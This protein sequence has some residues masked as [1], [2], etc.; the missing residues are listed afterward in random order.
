MKRGYTAVPKAVLVMTVLLL[1]GCMV[2]E[3]SNYPKPVDE[4]KM[5]TTHINLGLRYV[6]RGNREMARHHLDKA[7]AIDSRSS[8]ALTGYALVYEQEGEHEL[9]EDNF[10]RAMSADPSDTR[11][12]FYYAVY[13]NTRD[14]FVEAR[15]HFIQVTE[16]VGY[17]HRALAFASLGQVEAEMGN[18]DAARQALER[19]L[20]INPK[21]P[22]VYMELAELEYQ[23][24]NFKTANTNLKYFSQFS[25]GPSPRSLW[26]GIRLEREFNNKDAEASYGLALKNMFPESDENQAYQEWLKTR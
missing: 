19:A 7:L 5:L 23:A 17:P 25:K 13:L 11:A 20:R 4:D 14:R 12:R 2:T 18:S 1:C 22:Q 3:S 9:A 21:L 15:K 24:G 10:K 26:L 6:S 8:G 16:D